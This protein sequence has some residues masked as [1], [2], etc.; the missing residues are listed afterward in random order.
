MNKKNLCNKLIG[1]ITL[2]LALCFGYAY[3]LEHD[4][5]YVTPTDKQIQNYKI[6]ASVALNLYQLMKDTHEILTKH[7]IEYWIEGGTLLGAVRHKGIIPFDDDLDI[8]IMDAEESKLQ[9]IFPEFKKLG[10]FVK[11]KEI[12]SICNK[13][14]LDIFIFHKDKESDRLIY[15]DISMRTKYP[16][17][18]FYE[19]E[20]FPLKKYQFGEIEVYGP[21]DSKRNLDRMYPEWDKYAVIYHSH[22]HHNTSISNITLKTKFILTPEL[23]KPAMP[24]GPLKNRVNL[25]L[26]FFLVCFCA[27]ILKQTA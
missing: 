24:T 25:A 20:L 17:D 2:I 27:F 12:Y 23:L 18:Y 22:G 11:H 13:I 3:V 4:W 9:G 5:R 1:L 16:H 19:D 7:N 14:C 21:H 15:T 26:L 8:G 10:Y 6:K